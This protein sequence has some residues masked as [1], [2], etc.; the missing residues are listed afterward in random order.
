M[1]GSYYVAVMQGSYYVALTCHA[2]T[3][4]YILIHGPIFFF[5]IT[6]IF[7]P[8]RSESPSIFLSHSLSLSSRPLC[9]SLKHSLTLHMCSSF[10][11][12]KGRSLVCPLSRGPKPSAFCACNL[13]TSHSWEPRGNYLLSTLH[14]MSPIKCSITYCI[15]VLYIKLYPT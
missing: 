3:H 4:I 15:C 8:H 9:S 11:Y 5:L 1:Q 14:E 13:R 12:Q 2:P 10:L 6:R 7:L